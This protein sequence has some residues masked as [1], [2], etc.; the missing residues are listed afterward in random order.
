MKTFVSF[1][2]DNDRQYKYTLNMWASNSNIDF[3]FNDGSTQE[4]QSWNIG[5][6]K[7]AITIKIKEADCLL[8]IIG[9]YSNSY[10]KD[11][12]LIGFKN[13]QYFEIAKAIELGKKVVAV[14]L[15]RIFDTPDI[16]Y[17]QG[18]SWAMSFTLESVK[19]ALHKA[20]F[21]W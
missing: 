20:K 11:R 7:A 15:D 1:D 10:H 8:A 3:S 9:R 19:A 13:W 6:V 12:N 5:R 18:V 16:L 21:G 2:F 17:N 14:K 4:I